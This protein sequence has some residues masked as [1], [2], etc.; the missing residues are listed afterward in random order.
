M[1]KKKIAMLLTFIMTVGCIDSAMAVSG[2][3]F[4]SDVVQDG[5]ESI[6]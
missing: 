4:A 2:A 5:S 6:P 1:R 3:E